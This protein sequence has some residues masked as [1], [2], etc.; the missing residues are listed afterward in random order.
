MQTLPDIPS[1][2]LDTELL[3]E[4]PHQLEIFS[5]DTRGNAV[6]ARFPFKVIKLPPNLKTVLTKNDT[7]EIS[8]EPYI[9]N[10]LAGYRI[11]YSDTKELDNWELAADENIVTND[12]KS[13]TFNGPEDFQSPSEKDEFYFYLTAVDDKG[14][15]SAPSDIY[16]LSLKSNC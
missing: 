7:I 14:I 6:S 15:E 2:V 10:N 11:Y 9:L 3:D 1:T 5:E 16:S 12:Y 4:G 13:I 8:W